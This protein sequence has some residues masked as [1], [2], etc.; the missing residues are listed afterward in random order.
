MCACIVNGKCWD[1]RFIQY[2]FI[3]KKKSL[4]FFNDNKFFKFFASF[5]VSARKDFYLRWTCNAPQDHI[6]VCKV[7]PMNW[8]IWQFIAAEIASK[9]LNAKYW[10][11]V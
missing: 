11:Q 6:N 8:S 5:D 4:K 9:L 1:D 10:L 3:K 2:I 7:L